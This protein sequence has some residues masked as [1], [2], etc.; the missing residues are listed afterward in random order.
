MNKV[1]RLEPEAEIYIT[2]HSLGGALAQF[3]FV[4]SG[5]KHKT[6][7]WNSLGIGE[8]DKSLGMEIMFMGLNFELQKLGYLSKENG[9]LTNKCEQKSI[10]II[11]SI[12]EYF[13]NDKIAIKKFDEHRNLIIK[14]IKNLYKF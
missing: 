9:M 7:T 2:G 4:Y 1:K 10:E 6:V 11:N 3:V 14:R 12:K 13:K 8:V 5:G